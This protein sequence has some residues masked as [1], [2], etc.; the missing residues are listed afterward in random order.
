MES[1]LNANRDFVLGAVFFGAI[2][3]LIYYT[4]ALTGW[5]LEEKQMTTVYFPGAMGL[6]GGDPVLVAGTP[7]GHVRSIQFHDVDDPTRR[8]RVEIEFEES[9]TFYEDYSMVIAEFTM[10]GGRVIEVEPGLPGGKVLSSNVDLYG[11]VGGTVLGQINELVTENREK[12]TLIVDNIVELSQSLADEDGV[13]GAL[14]S[15]E[16]M[17]EDLITILRETS[18][19]VVTLKEIGEEMLA[20]KGVLG[21]ML[22]DEQAREEARIA[23]ANLHESSTR[24]DRMLA[25]LEGGEGTLGMLL[26]DA[27]TA[28]RS[29]TLVDNLSRLVQGLNDGEG[30]I[31]RL[32]KDEEAYT[33]LMTALETLNIAIE[34]A[35]EAA[36]IATFSQ[37]LFGAY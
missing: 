8:I 3:L 28:E 35:R 32:L 30:T 19:G 27:E 24:V 6:K 31:G 22:K 29:R 14:I 9:V 33:E 10:L 36:P 11:T 16:G 2:T 12:L 21:M 5:S 18:E 34:D 4:V 23:I 15:D 20:G 1:K 17:R 7:T 26:N 25:K 37:I 13:I